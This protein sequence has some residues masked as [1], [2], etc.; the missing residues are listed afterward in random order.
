MTRRNRFRSATRCLHG[1]EAGVGPAFRQLRTRLIRMMSFPGTVRQIRP[2]LFA[3]GPLRFLAYNA[4]PLGSWTVEI[5]SPNDSINAR[6]QRLCTAAILWLT[7]STVRPPVAT[8]SIL[9]RHFF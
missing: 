4:V 2:M 1:D 5:N 7:K 8:S 6:R 3:T 9:P